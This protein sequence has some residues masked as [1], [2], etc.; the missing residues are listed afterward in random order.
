MASGPTAIA[1]MMCG[2]RFVKYSV[3][4]M[5]DPANGLDPYSDQRVTYA[6][7]NAAANA[8]ASSITLRCRSTRRG[9]RM[10]YQPTSR[11]PPLAT[12]HVVLRRVRASRDIG[13]PLFPCVTRKK[14]PDGLLRLAEPP[15][16]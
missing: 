2:T 13:Q 1:R 8:V 10:R 7:R 12:M 15:R 4:Q 6:T 16:R 11:Q 5:P 3:R 9:T 14:N